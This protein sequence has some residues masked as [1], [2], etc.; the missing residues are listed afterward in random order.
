M[1]KLA[2]IVCIFLVS[3]F[4][5]AK[6]LFEEYKTKILETNNQDVIIADSS[7]F[8]VGASGIVSHKFDEKTSSIIA[9]VSVMSKGNGKAILRVEKF[10]MLTQGAFPDTN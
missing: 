8:V 7:D 6:P 3:S 9:Q 1:N 4:L 2:I 10:E 5:E